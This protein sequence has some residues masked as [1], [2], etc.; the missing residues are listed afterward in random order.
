M[1]H[2]STKY[3]HVY[4]V[5]PGEKIED[6]TFNVGGWIWFDESGML[7]TRLSF[8][9]EKDA[10]D[11]LCRYA[12][13]CLSRDASP[14]NS[15]LE[16]GTFLPWRQASTSWY[17]AY[18]PNPDGTQGVRFSLSIHPT[19]YRR[20]MYRLLIEVFG[21]KYHHDWGC[22]DDADQPARNYHN[23]FVALVEADSI[24]RILLIYLLEKHPFRWSLG[25]PKGLL[26]T[27]NGTILVNDRKYENGHPVLYG[28]LEGELEEHA[29]PINWISKEKV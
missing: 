27:R 15:W 14:I 18:L 2:S 24:A 11:E 7:G 21:G 22:F 23:H 8:P 28:K 29:I 10:H 19:C 16:M 3:R 25:E 26:R 1:S 5:E 6:H 4:Y 20:G 9:T 13:T 17:E 12:T